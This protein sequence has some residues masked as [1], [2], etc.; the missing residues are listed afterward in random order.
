MSLIVAVKHC[1]GISEQKGFVH[2]LSFFNFL[3]IYNPIH[4]VYRINI[5][6]KGLNDKTYIYD[7]H[8]VRN[9]PFYASSDFFG[10]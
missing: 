6:S 7:I 10:C 9:V 3:K 1:T 2:R 8:F 5:E 4:P